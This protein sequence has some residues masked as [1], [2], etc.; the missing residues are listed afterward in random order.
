MGKCNVKRIG[1]W[2]F[3]QSCP[4]LVTP[5][6]VACQAPLSMGF[7]MQEYWS[8]LPF[9][10]LVDLPY[11]GIKQASAAL[12]GRFFGA[13]PPGKPLKRIKVPLNTHCMNIN[14]PV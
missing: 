11:P 9:P 5:W 12:T 14:K 6:A 8:R 2:W 10:L 1:A 7:S 13:E 4:T 3:S